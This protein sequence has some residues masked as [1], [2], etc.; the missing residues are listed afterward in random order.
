M[1]IVIDPDELNRFAAFATEAADDYGMRASRI[2]ALEIPPMPREVA[3][4]VADALGR[5]AADLT[6]LSAGL[7]AE[8][9]L[10]RTRAALLDPVVSRYLPANLS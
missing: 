1:R 5:V 10:L 4:V 6:D 7:Y 9:T 8:A 2:T 3:A